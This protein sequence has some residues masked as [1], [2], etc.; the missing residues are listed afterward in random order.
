MP[1]SRASRRA[2]A[3]ASYHFTSPAAGLRFDFYADDD[4]RA[5]RTPSPGSAYDAA[6]RRFSTR[7][8][9]LTLLLLA[10]RDDDELA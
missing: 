2:T 4:A 1:M 3:R 10:G 9:G 7:A 5:A 6:S 8:A